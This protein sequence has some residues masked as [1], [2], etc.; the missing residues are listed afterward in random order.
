MNPSSPCMEMI[1]SV[2]RYAHRDMAEGEEGRVA[3]HLDECPS[4]R[5]FVNFIQEFSEA[6]K[7]QRLTPDE[8]HPESSVIVALEAEELD[9]EESERVFA[10]VLRCDTCRKE[11]LF[12]SGVS[13]AAIRER[14]FATDVLSVKDRAREWIKAL[15]SYLGDRIINI[16]K[17]YDPGTVIGG[18]R[19]L[20]EAPAFGFR[21]GAPEKAPSKLLEV[22][23]DG[24]TYGVTIGIDAEGSPWCDIAG[25]T[26]EEGPVA[27]TFYSDE[28]EEF[29][30]SKTDEH[31]NGHFTV[32][33]PARELLIIE[34]Q[35][36]GV[37]N[38]IPIKITTA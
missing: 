8:P 4:C 36:Q 29:L 17:T 20:A 18:V 16:A 28:G 23:V 12:L 11:Y 1:D 19:V 15:L 32:P 22:A 14:L 10:H 13:G 35:R 30:S 5:D 2:T 37:E 38:W 26:G 9:K 25:V 21:G 24:F 6:G 3:K 27:V 34:L 7:Q 33:R 31:G